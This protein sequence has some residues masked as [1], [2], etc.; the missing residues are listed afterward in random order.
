MKKSV[1][2]LSHERQLTCKA[3]G[4]LYPIL[5]ESAVPGGKYKFNTECLARMTPLI[6]PVYSRFDMYMHYFFVPNRI[7]WD[8]WEEFINPSNALNP[9]A[10]VF[11]SASVQA[12][13]ITDGANSI[14][15]NECLAGS[16]ADHL[17]LQI[18][19]ALPHTGNSIREVSLLPFRAYQQIW[20]DHFRDTDLEPEIEFP[21]TDGYE[22]HD[23]QT[24]EL[25][26]RKKAWEKDYYT[27]ARP[28]P[29]RGTAMAAPLTGIAQIGNYI[30]TTALQPSPT[31]YRG[32]TGARAGNGAISSLVVGGEGGSLTVAGAST[33]PLKID[34]RGTQQTNLGVYGGA[35]S[36]DFPRLEIEALREANAIQRLLE[37]SLRAGAHYWDMLSTFF[38]VKTRD[39]RF[40]KSEFI[41]GARQP[42]TISEVLQTS[43][44]DTTPLGTYGGHGISS[45]SNKIG[46]FVAPE[47]GYIIGLLSIM[48]RAVYL[49]Q[50]RR[51]FFKISRFDFYFPDLAN[52]GEQEVYNSEIRAGLAEADEGATFGYQER[53]AEHRFIPSTVHG[54]FRSD[55]V[56]KNFTAARAGASS[57]VLDSDFIHVTADDDTERIFAIDTYDPFLVNIMSHVTAVLPLPRHSNPSLL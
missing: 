55:A 5:C 14:P 43:Q 17:G 2:D 52:L 54:Q 50:I 1:F 41:G 38:G 11:P 9:Q 39:S 25:V 40:Q 19:S 31:L 13:V 47:H 45:G 15:Y 21:K 24:M 57:Y 34:F 16:L 23:G 22:Y 44:S 8:N 4:T 56:L 26:L 7:I 18:N 37:R 28:Y 53:W 35:S 51:D 36:A 27:S 30:P 6:N 49:N 48:P 32:D 10:V 3:D 42:V 46:T 12:G 29:Q 20:N 33:I